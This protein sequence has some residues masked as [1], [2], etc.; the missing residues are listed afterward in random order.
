MILQ[1]CRPVG[2]GGGGGGG[3]GEVISRLR[4]A[5]NSPSKDLVC[6]SIDLIVKKKKKKWKRKW[7]GWGER[8][9]VGEGGERRK[10][11]A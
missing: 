11:E 1:V 6:R 2:M 4:L 10:K 7:V 8:G 5:L 3:R 9:R